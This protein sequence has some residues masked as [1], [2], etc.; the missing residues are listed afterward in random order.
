MDYEIADVA[1]RSSRRRDLAHDTIGLRNIFA[2]AGRF[3]AAKRVNGE[4]RCGA[5]P[6]P[7]SPPQQPPLP[8]PMMTPIEVGVVG[9]R[10]RFIPIEPP[11]E[12]HRTDHCSDRQNDRHR[13]DHEFRGT[14]ATKC[15]RVF[16]GRIGRPLRREVGDREVQRPGVR[17]RLR[18]DKDCKLAELGRGAAHSGGRRLGFGVPP[19]RD[20]SG[21]CSAANCR[22]EAGHPAEDPRCPPG[23]HL[24]GA[25]RPAHRGPSAGGGH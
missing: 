13:D 17:D 9:R 24:H 4:C 8:V 19:E 12:D 21:C 6:A 25:V 2:V 20:D 5:R 3:I 11:R 18:D 16:S 7:I 15:T 22:G 10:A 23:H 14:H 1:R